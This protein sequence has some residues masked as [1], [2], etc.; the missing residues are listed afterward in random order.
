MALLTVMREVPKCSVNSASVG[1]L[2]PGGHLPA[3]M[4]WLKTRRI[5]SQT[6]PF[7]SS[8]PIDD[9]VAGD[10]VDDQFVWSGNA[11]L[12]LLCCVGMVFRYAYPSW[13]SLSY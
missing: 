9:T 12:V 6:G 2:V 4:G 10:S 7:P 13:S 3:W 1:N 11:R 5:C 8:L